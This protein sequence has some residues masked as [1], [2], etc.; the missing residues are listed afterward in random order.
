[1]A[2]DELPRQYKPI[3]W[4]GLLATTL[5]FALGGAV[6]G[7]LWV[8]L[9]NPLPAFGLMGGCG[10]A[11]AGAFD[12]SGR[13]ALVRILAGALGFSVGFILG[14]FVVLTV[15]EP[16]FSRLL[17]GALGGATGGLHAWLFALVGEAWFR[18]AVQAPVRERMRARPVRHC[19]DMKVHR[20]YQ[21]VAMVCVGL[22]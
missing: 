14:F 13:R 20:P 17:I 18:S 16:R 5:S 7:W 4:A 21:I 1:M 10:A 15:W 12:R 22:K 8:S 2:T 9:D 6:G 19:I 11:G 3:L